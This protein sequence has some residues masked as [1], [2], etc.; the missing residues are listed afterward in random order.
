MKLYGRRIA[1]WKHLWTAGGV[2]LEFLETEV[3]SARGSIIWT[4]E[5]SRPAKLDYRV[6]WDGRGCTRLLE[7]RLCSLEPRVL[8][9]ESNGEGTWRRDGTELRELRGCLDVDVWPTPFTNTLPFQRL[10]ASGSV[11]LE[12]RVVHIIAPELSVAA[13]PQRY[14]SVGARRYRF[15]SLDD[16]FSAMLTFGG[17]GLVESYEGFFERIA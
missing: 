4:D 11:G 6:V 7:C 10:G 14:T 16:Q 2:G 5:N 9:L 13:R 8:L 3:D 15:E 12:V 17:D 1:V